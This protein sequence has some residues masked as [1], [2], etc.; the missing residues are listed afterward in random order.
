MIKGLDKFR[1]HFEQNPDAFVLIGG[2]A[3]TSGLLPKAMISIASS[4]ETSLFT[5]VSIFD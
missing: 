1:A 5:V 3:S 4:T 2:A